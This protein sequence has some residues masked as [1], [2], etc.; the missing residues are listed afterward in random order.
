MGYIL[1]GITHERYCRLQKRNDYKDQ[2][3]KTAAAEA[4]EVSIKVCK[5]EIT[6]M[7][8]MQV[9]KKTISGGARGNRTPDLLLIQGVALPTELP[10]H[11]HKL[12]QLERKISVKIW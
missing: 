7:R 11:Y 9:V 8:L 3:A 10:P 6:T 1:V 4:D 2:E 12:Y 5:T